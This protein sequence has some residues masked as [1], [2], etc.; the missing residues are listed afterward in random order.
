MLS[1]ER[2]SFLSRRVYENLKTYS[3]K[4]FAIL[5]IALL[6]TTPGGIQLSYVSPVSVIEPRP[7]TYEVEVR[8]VLSTDSPR[9]VITPAKISKIVPGESVHDRDARLVA[10]EAVQAAAAK[11][12]VAKKATTAQK[13]AVAST[14][15][16][17]ADFKALYRAAGGAFGVAPEI[18]EAIHQVETGKSGST[19]R[20]N[21][22]GATG[23][24]QFLVSTF[25]NHSVDGNG[26]GVKDVHN[27][28]DAVFS[29][30]KYL[31]DCGYQTDVKKALW[32]Y[33]PSTSYCNRV[34]AI[35]R[36]IGFQG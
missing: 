13:T 1:F 32:G 10:E 5:P 7:A 14:V 9:V 26:D 12:A 18:I 6:V 27:V 24:M 31:R 36:S 3:K 19:A 29:A 20:S 23:P 35:A 17:P 16:D 34:L 28:S 4:L 2:L 25:R 33:N 30:A 21:P 8:V 11:A 22:S 15:P